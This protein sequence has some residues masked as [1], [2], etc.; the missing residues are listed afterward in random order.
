MSTALTNS[1][2]SSFGLSVL[3]LLPSLVLAGGGSVENVRVV[4]PGE[5][6]SSDQ[7]IGEVAR[8]SRIRGDFFGS[9]KLG[10]NHVLVVQLEYFCFF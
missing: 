2:S 4:Y 5:Q 1:S 8:Y 3:K 6:P 7:L 9:D 10:S